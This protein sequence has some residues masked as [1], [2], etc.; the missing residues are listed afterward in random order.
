MKFS[1]WESFGDNLRLESEILEDF[2]R[3]W[4]ITLLI[5]KENSRE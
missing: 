3:F 2:G 1:V 4:K 5:A